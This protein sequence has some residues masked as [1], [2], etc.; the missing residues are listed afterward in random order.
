[1]T[2]EQRQEMYAELNELRARLSRPG[3]AGVIAEY[4]ARIAYL[5]DELGIK[6]QCADRCALRVLGHRTLDV[7]WFESGL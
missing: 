6:S 1:M 3:E 5:E 2:A 7:D 4:E